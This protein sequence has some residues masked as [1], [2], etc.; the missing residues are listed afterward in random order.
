MYLKIV[1]N[2]F[3]VNIVPKNIKKGFLKGVLKLKGFRAY[4]EGFLT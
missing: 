3:F 4:R 1:K 2:L